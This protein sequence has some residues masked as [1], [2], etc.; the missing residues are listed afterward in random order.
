MNQELNNK[1]VYQDEE[2]S[3]IEI[4][5]VLWRR[6]WFLVVFNI[7]FISAF[8]IFFTIYG[9]KKFSK[10]DTSKLNVTIN[11]LPIDAP[12]IKY[13]IFNI[14]NR[15]IKYT[16]FKENLSFKLKDF[17]L[18]SSRTLKLNIVSNK[19]SNLALKKAIY[20]K[21]SN[22]YKLAYLYYN[23]K[24]YTDQIMNTYDIALSGEKDLTDNQIEI[25]S[26]KKMFS[27]LI[28]ND[29]FTD[30]VNFSQT[31]VLTNV[32]SNLTTSIK[33]RFKKIKHLST[34]PQILKGIMLTRDNLIGFINSIKND[35]PMSVSVST[36][37]IQKKSKTELILVVGIFMS[38]IISILL[39]FILEY[40][41]N[42][43]DE[44][45]KKLKENS[46]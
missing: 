33:T 29:I 40:W 4:I 1:D 46:K 37:I 32:S 18:E 24:I 42:N 3:L 2:I 36:K 22:I 39:A 6:R 7:L 19:L 34:N 14:I 35:K 8:L 25:I 44:I 30:I 31:E 10:M 16:K 21:Y 5:A 26:K 27:R 12:N 38:F 28:F 15:D 23:L 11:S 9:A 43:K 20:N 45:L 13:A 17:K 41:K